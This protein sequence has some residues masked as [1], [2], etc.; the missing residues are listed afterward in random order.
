MCVLKRCRFGRCSAGPAEVTYHANY[1]AN[2]MKIEKLQKAKVW[3]EACHE[4]AP[5]PPELG[6]SRAAAQPDDARID[7]RIKTVAR[8]RAG[9]YADKGAH[10]EFAN[11][12][13]VTAA[14]LAYYDIYENWKC[15]ADRLS[16]DWAV[17]GA[18][19]RGRRIRGQKNRKHRRVI[20]TSEI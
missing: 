6:S 10:P 17:S 20:L 19:I 11:I 2:E 8:K 14:N 1:A 7:E 12:L 16:L 18:G 15:F 3:G 9:L 5:A 4:P 13:L